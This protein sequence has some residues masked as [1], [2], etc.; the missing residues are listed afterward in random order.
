[1]SN[2][3]RVK[4]PMIYDFNGCANL[5]LHIEVEENIAEGLD[6]ITLISDWGE[7]IE[8][9]YTGHGLWMVLKDLNDGA[10]A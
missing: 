3:N 5:Y 7:I 8:K 4:I 2:V 1:M 6:I 10:Y 9:T